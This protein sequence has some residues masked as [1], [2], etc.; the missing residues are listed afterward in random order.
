M[1]RYS[2]AGPNILP[3]LTQQFHLAHAQLNSKIEGTRYY[4]WQ[5]LAQTAQTLH[6]IPDYF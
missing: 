4:H 6:T 2:Q 5:Y 3:M 1:T